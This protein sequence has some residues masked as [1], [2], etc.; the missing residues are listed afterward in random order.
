MI[1]Y[2]YQYI[3]FSER[4]PDKE[5]TIGYLT[6]EKLRD[7]RALSFTRKY[8]KSPLDHWTDYI[9][10]THGPQ[11]ARHHVVLGLIDIILQASTASIQSVHAELRLALENLSNGIDPEL[12]LNKIRSVSEAERQIIEE[13][14]RQDK[15]L[16]EHEE[17]SRRVRQEAI[18]TIFGK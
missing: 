10:K 1:I 2:H 11:I 15:M 6:D 8:G 16:V 7:L 12:T 9:E 18:H 3:V 5:I 4:I 17:F 13:S 14:K